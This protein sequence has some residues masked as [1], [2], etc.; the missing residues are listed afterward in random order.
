MSTSEFDIVLLGATGYTGAITAEHITTNFPT[1]LKWAIA[2]RS[3]SSL[4]TLAAK[5]KTLDPDRAPPVIILAELEKEALHTLVRRTR[6]LINVV[7]PYHRYSE[8]VVEACAKEGVN[9]V[10][11]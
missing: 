5:L 10:D 8:P 2:G 9:Y 6:V 4:E 11:L 1:T 7:G 3:P